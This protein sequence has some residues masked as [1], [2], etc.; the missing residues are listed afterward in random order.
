MDLKILWQDK[1][2]YLTC[3]YGEP[4]KGRRSDVWER[5]TRIG[6]LRTGPWV[7]TRDFNELTD[8]SEKIGGA[9]RGEEEG[10]DFRQMLRACGLWNIKHIGYQFSW[11]GT[12]NNETVQCRLDRTVANQECSDKFPKASATYL[13]KVCSD[14]SP[15][16][17]TLVERLWKN[18]ANFKYDQRWIKR[19]GFSDTVNQ[20]WKRQASGQGSLLGK[21]ASCRRDISIWKR[22]AKPNSAL[23]IQELHSKIDEA[24]RNCFANR[25]E[26]SNL[27]EALNEEYYNE[28]N[29]WRQKSRLN[30]LRSGDRNTKFFH[31]VTKNRRAQNRIL[32][33]FDENDVEWFDED[34]IGKIAD[35]HF[36]LLYSSEDVGIGLDSWSDIPPIITE[37][38]NISLVAPA[39][40][41]EVKAAVFDI[42][43]NKY[44]GPESMNGFFFQQFWETMSEDIFTMVNNFLSTGKLEDG[45]NKTNICLIPKKL[46]AKKLV[47]FR[48]ISLC[49]IS[50]KIVSK[51]L[52]KRLKSVLPD[53]ITE[54]QAAFVEDRLI[55]D[56]ILVAHEL[57]H[58]LNSNNS[59]S[60][61]Y[62]AVKTDL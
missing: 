31:A 26:L 50:Y 15:V 52:S 11:A 22:G 23:R 7:M 58:A 35:R 4:I 30:W 62:I 18:R 56:N 13:Q 59:C 2:F 41:E 36:K 17:T 8:S 38:Q 1:S 51:L 5:I 46:E 40:K 28:E 3:V 47:D 49:N 57:L 44:P 45:I 42:N 53:L 21:I 34:N 14:H 39:T 48:P 37:E 27:R 25:E 55:S 60:R 9:E 19:E 6:T 61:D 43:P 10:K 54:T 16:L 32:S 20:S 24:T 33:L 12:R 29:F